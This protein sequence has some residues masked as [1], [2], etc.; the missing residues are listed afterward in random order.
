[1]NSTY[2]HAGAETIFTASNRA[3]GPRI[4][5]INCGS[6]SL[7]FA[8][9]APDY[10]PRRL[11]SGQVERIGMADSRLRMAETDGAHKVDE[12]VEVP[13]QAAAVT[14]LVERLGRLVGLENIAVVGHRIVHGGDRFHR[15]ERITPE[16]LDDAA[17]DR[18][19]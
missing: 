2:H 7:K 3:D 19:L 14:L 16:V 4:L 8:L 12:S 5:T 9:F 13:D 11:L 18:P 17:Q 1:M 10:R 6:S 15:P